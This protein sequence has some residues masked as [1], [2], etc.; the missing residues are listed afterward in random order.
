MK[1]SKIL[2]L[3]NKNSSVKSP[4]ILKADKIIRTVLLIFMIL[5]V[6]LLTS[7]YVEGHGPDRHEGYRHHEHHERDD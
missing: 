4:I 2:H 1:T 5:Y 3:N 6:T 7:C